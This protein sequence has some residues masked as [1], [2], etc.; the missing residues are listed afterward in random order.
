[1]LDSISNTFTVVMVM[2]IKTN[3]IKMD[4]SKV[5]STRNYLEKAFGQ[6]EVEEKM[7]DIQGKAFQ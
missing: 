7:E 4:K 1:M 3:I 6:T 2:A 5:R